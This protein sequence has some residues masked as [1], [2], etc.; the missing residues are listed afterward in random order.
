MLLSLKNNEIHKNLNTVVINLFIIAKTIIIQKNIS[1]LFSLSVNLLVSNLV[2]KTLT[3]NLGLLLSEK[4]V[5]NNNNIEGILIK[6]LSSVLFNKAK[7][8]IHNWDGFK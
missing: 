2:C 7:I 6:V 1:Q 3:L 8:I 5:L 4:K